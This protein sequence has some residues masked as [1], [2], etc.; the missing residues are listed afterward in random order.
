MQQ[1]FKTL[2][3]LGTQNQQGFRKKSDF[4]FAMKKSHLTLEQR[5]QI[6]AYLEAGK[7]QSEISILIG[8]DKSVLSRELK[9]NINLKGLYKANN[10]NQ[11]S[12][13][14]KERLKRSRKL[15]LDMEQDIRKIL[16]E[17][18]WSPKQIKGRFEK[19]GRSMV[20]HERIYQLIRQDKL[21]GGILYKHTRHRLKHRKRPV[22][23]KKIVI[24]NK[25]SIDERPAIINDKLRF[26]D[27]EIDTIVGMENK[28]AIVTIVERQTGFL[29]MKKLPKGKNAKGLADIVVAILMPYK[30]HVQS[31]T[32][33]NGTEFA[34]HQFITKKLNT[35]FFF[36]HAYSSWERGLNENT[37]KLI[38]QYIPKKET[39]ERYN[40]QYIKEIQH[41]INNRP[42]EK[43]KF[44]NPKHIFYNNLDNKVALAS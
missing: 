15:S 39:F 36:A 10:A 23:G 27:W 5:Y 7:N 26:W 21:D 28:G 25:V 11:I 8:K 24:R 43:L 2:L 14:R 32:S 20:S 41:K 17:E 1:K 3:I 44:N 42:R 12:Q 34:E 40:E 18:Q 22:G 30:Q 6:Q 38:R 29:L 19:E 33:D 16:V 35:D 4:C 13:I 31:I 37:N 9:R